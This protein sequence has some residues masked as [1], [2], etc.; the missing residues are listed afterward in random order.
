MKVILLQDVANVGRRFSVVDVSNGHALNK[1]IPNKQA[2]PATPEN[3]KRFE[4]R[5]ARSEA[6]QAAVNESFAE[7][8]TRISDSTQTITVDANEKGHLFKGLKSADIAEE[9]SKLG[10][11]VAANQV[12]LEAP[13]KE[14]G[15]HKIIISDG[16][17]KATFT[18]AVTTK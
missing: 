1:L 15:E 12:V 5:K 16:E 7:V 8:V 11:A 3:L 4:A 14:V 2:E 9:L 10:F 18:L 17:Q 13:I 6:E